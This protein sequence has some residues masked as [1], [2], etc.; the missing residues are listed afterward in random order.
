MANRPA[1]TLPAASPEF[2][3][4]LTVEAAD[5]DALGHVNNIVYVR[6]LQDVATAHANAAGVSHADLVRIGAVFVVRK[7]EIEYLR[8]GFLGERIILRTHVSWWK[9]AS[10][11]RVTS[12][13]RV[14]D[15][16][17]LARAKTLWA[18]VNAQ[19]GKPT[20]LPPEVV[21]AFASSATS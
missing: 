7:H 18:F 17:V 4:E 14:S 15:G 21:N 1:S 16:A 9:G 19:T 10:C 12:I 5:V 11:E 2:A 8:P 3:L 13:D 6:W 20:R